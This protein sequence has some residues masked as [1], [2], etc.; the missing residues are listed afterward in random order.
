MS[1]MWSSSHHMAGT[2]AF[3]DDPRTSATDRDGRVRGTHNVFAA[4]ACLFPTTGHANPTVGAVALGLH[5]AAAASRLVRGVR[6][7]SLSAL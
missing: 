1:P 5:V 2:L 6:S 7:D 3:G 4:G